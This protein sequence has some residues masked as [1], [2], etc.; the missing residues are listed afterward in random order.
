MWLRSGIP[1]WSISTDRRSMSLRDVGNGL[2]VLADESISARTAGVSSSPAAMRAQGGG[3]Y[4]AP[5]RHGTNRDHR[6]EGF[7]A[8][9]RPRLVPGAVVTDPARRATR[10]D[11]RCMGRGNPPPNAD[12]QAVRRLRRARQARFPDLS[13]PPGAQSLQRAVRPSNCLL[14]ILSASRTR[15]H[16][17]PTAR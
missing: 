8:S 14:G 9:R 3:K 17:S 1:P 11:R 4:E 6:T 12:A 2:H 16:P 13:R 7:L 10:L 5:N 15:P